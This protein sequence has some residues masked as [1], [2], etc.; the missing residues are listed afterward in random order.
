MRGFRIS[1]KNP[2]SGYCPFLLSLCR[3]PPAEA[4]GRYAGALCEKRAAHKS[5]RRDGATE[6]TEA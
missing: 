5:A 6:I 2:P 1:P 3:N 4:K